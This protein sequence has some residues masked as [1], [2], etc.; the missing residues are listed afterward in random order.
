LSQ[1][2]SSSKG[3]EEEKDPLEE[4]QKFTK[5]MA[6]SSIIES[7]VAKARA[8][9]REA[10]AKADRAEKGE[11]GD[12]SS[13]AGFKV[14][15]GVDLG[16]LDLAKERE[17][18]AD[19]LRRL[20][21]EA[22]GSAKAI[23]QE[24]QQLREKIHEQEMHVLEITLKTQIEQLG[25]LIKG[26]ASRGS[27]MDQYTSAMEMAKTL[28]FSQPTTGGDLSTQL[29]LK[30]IEFDQML[31]MKKWTR[32]EKRADREFQ[33]QLN[34]DNDER[35]ARKA[36]AERLGKRDEMF[37]SFP[38]HIGG[39]IARGLM[40]SGGEAETA[41][42]KGKHPGFTAGI[43]EG[44][45]MECPSCG[46]PMAIGP[47]AVKAVCANCGGSFPIKRVKPVEEE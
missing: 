23:G 34:V 26:N 24:N 11:R 15:G 30:K 25:E 39:A 3:S 44:G 45:E 38:Q 12:E 17:E 41:P 27:F 37:A 14:T 18:A 4:A 1:P 22:D 29:A 47:T 13:K 32:E 19:E 36:E 7:T 16:H 6:A 33:R 2:G 5:Q 35:A 20:K 9:A 21:A 8:E 46:Q 40:E 43:G 28:G 42:I 10:T 31:E